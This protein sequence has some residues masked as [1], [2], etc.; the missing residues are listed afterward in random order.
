MKG[1]D[2]AGTSRENPS[3]DPLMKE[4]TAE[5]IKK[6]GSELEEVKKKL[7]EHSESKS[8]EE[9]KKILE[10]ITKKLEVSGCSNDQLLQWVNSNPKEV[11]NM[12]ERAAQRKSYGPTFARALGG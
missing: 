7:K 5:M 8:E 3:A 12:L 4:W 6:L 2:M 10:E 1:Q 11:S 9:K